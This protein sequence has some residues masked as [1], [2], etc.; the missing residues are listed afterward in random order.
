MLKQLDYLWLINHAISA[1]CAY[2][3]FFNNSEADRNNAARRY[4]NCL[5]VVKNMFIYGRILG[6]YAISVSNAITQ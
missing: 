3:M 2:L 1:L 4:S 5:A 6:I